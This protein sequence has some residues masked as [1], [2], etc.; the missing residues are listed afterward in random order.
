MSCYSVA[1][2]SANH[3]VEMRTQFQAGLPSTALLSYAPPGS[4]QVSGAGPGLDTS[5]NRKQQSNSALQ[6]RIPSSVERITITGS[7]FGAAPP[8]CE[9]G[10]YTLQSCSMTS[11]HRTVECTTVAGVGA[12]LAIKVTAGGQSGSGGSVSYKAPTV[13]G[14]SPLVISTNGGRLCFVAQT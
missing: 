8:L 11:P 2:L 10:S 14:V 7:N 12:N 6:F 4:I 9:Y 3:L 1:G 5:G 13:T